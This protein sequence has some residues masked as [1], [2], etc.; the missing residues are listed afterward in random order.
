MPLYMGN[1][2]CILQKV[3]SKRYNLSL[4]HFIGSVDENGILQHP[5][6]GNPDFTKIQT[7]SSAAGIDL[8]GV[9]NIT[10][11]IVLNIATI[12]DGIGGINLSDT[13]IN[14]LTCPKLHTINRSGAIKCSSSTIAIASFPKLEYIGS[15]GLNS[16]FR[17]SSIQSFTAPELIEIAVSGMQQA[18]DATDQIPTISFPKLQRIGLSGCASAFIDSRITDF[19]FPELQAIEGSAFRQA[20][21]NVWYSA[22]NVQLNPITFPKLTTIATDAFRNAFQQRN[23]VELHF[24]ADMEETVRA[25]SGYSDTKPFGATSGTVYFDL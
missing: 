13:A 11:D 15:A 3:P 20:F 21:A 9:T 12:T 22:N 8:S 23:N 6:I 17:L 1:K 4:E 5:L 2:R 16:A 25:L 19:S 18:F 10:G 7:I 14:S 24:R